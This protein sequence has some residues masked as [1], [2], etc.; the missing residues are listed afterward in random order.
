MKLRLALLSVS[1]FVLFL[2]HELVQELVTKT[3]GWRFGLFMTF[4]EIGSV[5]HAEFSIFIISISFIPFLQTLMFSS[6]LSI[7]SYLSI[8]EA[9]SFLLHLQLSLGKRP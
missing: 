9:Y 1:M 2:I 6:A 7:P 5:R 8:F 3:P 4:V